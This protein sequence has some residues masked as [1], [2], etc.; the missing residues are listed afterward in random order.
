MKGPFILIAGLLLTSCGGFELFGHKTNDKSR[1]IASITVKELASEEAQTFKTEIDEKLLSLHSYYVI[2][3]VELTKFDAQL[4]N[5]SLEELYKS[6]PYL[7]LTATRTQV[8][9]IEDE[10]FELWT[11]LNEKK[12]K[13]AN[14]KRDLLI[15]R[16]E[17]FS[18]ISHLSSLSM[19]MLEEKLAL[20]LIKVKNLKVTKEEISEEVKRLEVSKEFQIYEKNIEH[21]SHLMGPRVKEEGKTFYPS[22]LGNGELTGSEFPSKVWALTFDDGPT[23]NSTAA[24][25]KNL[26]VHDLKATFFQ[27]AQKVEDH[28]DL[29]KSVRDSG[30]EIGAHS[31]SHKLLTVV[32]SLT[33]EK[34]ITHSTRNIEKSLKLDIKFFRLPYGVG[35]SVPNIRQK[36][37]ENEL[38]HVG[39]TVDTLDWIVQTPDKIVKRARA[40]MKKSLKDSGIILFHDSHKTT[41]EASAILMKDLKENG[42][43]TCTVGEIVSQINE[44]VE[45]VCPKS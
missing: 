33:L 39:H 20:D 27:L 30:M 25:V 41:I 44:G 13:S 12:T 40:M 31:Y 7:S 28:K 3:Q 16:M 21:L 2:A 29:A 14:Q 11:S 35:A 37:V 22:T 8:D 26:K 18:D 45:T 19:K 5:S 38:I 4:E 36:L 43:R 6:P 34:E 42:R 9:E 17:A 24:I 23:K 15:Q 1:H 32:G 10:F